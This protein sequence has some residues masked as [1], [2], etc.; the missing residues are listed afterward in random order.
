MTAT[1]PRPRVPAYIVTG[2]LGAGKTTLLRRLIENASGQRFAVIVNEFGEMG[3]DGELIEACC[4]DVVE[5]KNGCVCCRIGYDLV[6]TLVVTYGP[7]ATSNRADLQKVMD[8]YR[9][10]RMGKV[11]KSVYGAD[12]RP[13]A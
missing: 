2:F 9:L 10:G 5:L 11:D 13:L 6:P 4:Q 3:F 8:D 12:D 1:P 7:F